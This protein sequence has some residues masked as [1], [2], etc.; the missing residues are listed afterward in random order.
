MKTKVFI[1]YDSE[2]VGY[3]GRVCHAL[4]RQAE[5]SC[6]FAPETMRSGVFPKQLKKAIETS[7]YFVL[8]LTN[9]TAGSRWQVFEIKEWKRYKERQNNTVI[10]NMDNKTLHLPLLNPELQRIFVNDT[11]DFDSSECS[12]K[13]LAYFNIIRQRINKEFHLY[14]LPIFIFCKSLD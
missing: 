6:F 13:I 3:V 5:V 8:F 10:V 11:L 2:I 4:N 12:D 14:Y 7:N 1:C 9:N